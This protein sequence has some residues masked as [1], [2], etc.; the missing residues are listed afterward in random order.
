MKKLRLLTRKRAKMRNSTYSVVTCMAEQRFNKKGCFTE[1]VN[2]PFAL[3]ERVCFY[4]HGNL[5]I[6]ITGVVG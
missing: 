3:D 6:K 1:K 5:L 4:Y 2:S